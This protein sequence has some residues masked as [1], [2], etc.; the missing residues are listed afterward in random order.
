MLRPTLLPLAVLAFAAAAHAGEAPLVI[1]D[2]EEGGLKPFEANDQIAIVAEHASS[3]THAVKVAP[4]GALSANG[5]SGL[6]A[7]WSKHDV[8]KFDV[9]VPGDQNVQLAIQIRD[10]M[11][12]P[13][14]WAWHNRYTGLAPGMNTVQFP[15]ADIWRGEVLR[16]DVA[17][18]LDPHAIKRFVIIPQNSPV[19]LFVDNIRLESF[20]APKVEV[21]G[22]KAFDVD[23]V[24]APGFVGFTSLTDQ[25]LYA[26]DKGFG[27]KPGS[28]FAN[29]N[30]GI[31]IRLQ[32]D[33]LFRDWI[34]LSNAELLVDL[35][36]GKYHV[37]MQLEDPGAWEYMQNYRK[38]TVTAEG[39]TVLDES[40]S[41]DDFL[42][43]YFR[44]Q[45]AED[46][47]GEDP[48]DKYVET[49]HPW[50]EFDVVVADGQLNLGFRSEDAYGATLSALV[51]SPVEQ[52]GKTRQFMTFVKEMR[53]VDWSQSWKG[54]SKPPTAPIFAGKAGAENQRDGFALYA[55]SPYAAQEYT[56]DVSNDPLPAKDAAVSALRLRAAIGETEPATFGLMPG[57]KLG[58][59]EVTVSS[60]KGPGGATLPPSSVQ[61]RVGRYRFSRHDGEQSGL[62]S[63]RERELRFFNRTEA[64][65]L[66][67]DDGMARRFWVI[68][69]VPETAKPG[70]YQ[71]QVTVTAEKGGKREFPIT[72]EALPFKLPMAKHGFTVY[73]C[74]VLPII[75]YD[76]QKKHQMQA[77]ETMLKDLSSHGMNYTTEPL[78]SPN[79]IW[80]D[81]KIEVTNLAEV[82]AGFELWRRYGFKMDCPVGFPAGGSVDAIIADQPINGMP[83]T[84]FIAGW[85][86]GLTDIAKARGWPHPGFCFGDEPNIPDTLNRLTAIH[87]A[88]HA[89]SPDIWT[90]IAYHLESPESVAMMKTVDVHH[91]KDF[92]SVEQFKQVKSQ[93][94]FL[95]NCNIGFGRTPF[96][97][98]EWRAAKERGTD[99]CITYSYTGSHIDLFYD[100]DGRESDYSCSPPRLDGTR[101]TVAYWECT[102]EGVDDFRYATAL[103]QLAEDG[104]APADAV[105]KAKD[106]LTEGYE[107]GATKSGKGL[108]GDGGAIG[109]ADAWR[110]KAQDLLVVVAGKK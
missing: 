101:D 7:D 40:M 6:V 91:F 77:N 65:T 35:P 28:Q 8:V 88:L 76:E 63:V 32:P 25:D 37:A 41:C 81:G 42:K 109:A 15:V 83:S 68:V 85:Y 5:Y 87:N 58:K 73:G 99:G 38:R 30:P 9:F 44:N 94:K 90:C 12:A 96:G 24:G 64:D 43:K 61:V 108:R 10:P 82:D 4:G 51:I 18:M 105:K 70:T 104:K 26:K 71:G 89:V 106:L 2:F 22:L 59:V 95:L 14:Y 60:L 72:V 110:R 46:L 100:L 55:V 50:R 20:P 45:D 54:V 102:R 31:C 1:A 97:L 39:A 69:E 33:N 98:H 92:S 3:G 86:Q 78:Y 34:S 93:A 49:R 56:G 19:P 47:P 48:F 80:K 21:P 11:D 29:T 62:Y 75:Y 36:N 67:C 23:P 66:R 57:R 84:Q 53:R 74:G 52:A 13:N 16:R 103:A 27:W 79:C 17:G 107:L